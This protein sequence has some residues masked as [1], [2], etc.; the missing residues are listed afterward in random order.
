MSFEISGSSLNPS[1][2]A[3]PHPEEMNACMALQLGSFASLRLT[4]RA[5]PAGLVAAAVL[6]AT[7]A[8]TSALVYR[9]RNTPPVLHS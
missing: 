2:T 6:F 1:A 4:A 5:T 9:W 3:A 8:T 7:M